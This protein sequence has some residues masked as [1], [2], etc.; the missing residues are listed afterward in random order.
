MATTHTYTTAGIAAG[1]VALVALAA[2]HVLGRGGDDGP[3]PAPAP[4]AS[5]APQ[6]PEWDLHPVAGRHEADRAGVTTDDGYTWT[7]HR[8]TPPGPVESVHD[9]LVVTGWTPL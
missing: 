7:L 6:L 1:V 3:A 8:G 5:A 9:D 2:P 4:V